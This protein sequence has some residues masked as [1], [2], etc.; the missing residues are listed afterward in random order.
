MA[1]AKGFF[2]VFRDP[3]GNIINP[4]GLSPECWNP[5]VGAPKPSPSPV[6]EPPPVSAPSPAAAKAAAAPP[7]Q[8]LR[9]VFFFSLGAVAAYAALSLRAGAVECVLACL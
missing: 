4:P 8:T 2:R 5:S 7:S 1:T 3:D 9:S 6:R